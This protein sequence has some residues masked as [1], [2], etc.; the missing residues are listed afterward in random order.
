MFLFRMVIFMTAAL[1]SGVSTFVFDFKVMGCETSGG[2]L[3]NLG[4]DGLCSVKVKI[5][6]VQLDL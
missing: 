5:F 3:M 2:V 6:A 1:L 4:S